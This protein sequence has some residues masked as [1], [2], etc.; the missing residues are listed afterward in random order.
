VRSRLAACVAFLAVLGV[1]TATAR[2]VTTEQ[3]VTVL[4]SV[5]ST[6]T[7]FTASFRTSVRTGSGPSTERYDLL[8]VTATAPAQDCLAG[9]SVR[10]PN[11]PA[12]ARVRVTLDPRRRSWCVGSYHGSV[13]ELQRPNCTRGQACPQ[14]VI[15]RRELGRVSLH[16]VDPA[17]SR[18]SGGDV[19]P[20]S[21]VG[22]ES[23][24]AC[25][26][27]A[28]RPGQTTPFTLTW[29]PA[30]DDQTPPA[31]LVYDVYLSATPGGE[32][33]S[34]PTWTTAPGVSS[35]RTPG[36]PSHGAFFFVVR[37][38]DQAGDEDQNKVERR[39]SDPCY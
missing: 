25:T 35:F 33:Y 29:L 12:G 2:G 31:Q 38:R 20:P 37:A 21:F 26:P 15:V 39:G 34:A 17:P 19:T 27:G 30:S 13:L 3:R 14:H 24:F 10:A 9:F 28:Q 36:L 7:A 4:P 1:W 18:S 5:G 6:H 16:V 22:L 23:A 8:T 11:A 32:N